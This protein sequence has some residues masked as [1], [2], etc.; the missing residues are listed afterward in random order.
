MIKNTTLFHNK[1]VLLNYKKTI[2]N[3]LIIE[4]YQKLL[5]KYKIAQMES[6]TKDSK[7]L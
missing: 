6:K 2:Y 7:K 5:L 4:T 3:I 1:V